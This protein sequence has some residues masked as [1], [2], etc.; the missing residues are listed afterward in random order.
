MEK[1][2]LSALDTGCLYHPGDIPGTHLLE[3]ELTAGPQCE[4]KDYVN[5]KSQ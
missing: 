5:E 1:E 3:G 2:K 4:R